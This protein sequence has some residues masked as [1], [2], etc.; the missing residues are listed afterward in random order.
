MLQINIDIKKVFYIVLGITV[1]YLISKAIGM[2]D[3]K[4]EAVKKLIPDKKDLIALSANLEGQ[5]SDLQVS[6][7]Q[8]ANPP[9][10]GG[11]VV[12]VPFSKAFAAQ[13]SVTIAQSEH[14]KAN[15]TG[16]LVLNGAG[17]EITRGVNLNQT[18]QDLII[19]FAQAETGTI[20]VS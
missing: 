19:T 14:G 3:K 2:Q 9:N 15:V 5:I 10:N 1:L 13:T 11:N 20:L 17:D 6:A 7:W 16:V 12:N 8:Q 4:L 18:T